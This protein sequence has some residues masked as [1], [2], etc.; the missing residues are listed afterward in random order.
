MNLFTPHCT[1]SIHTVYRKQRARSEQERQDVLDQ[2]GISIKDWM[3]GNNP[4]SKGGM[5]TPSSK[6][7]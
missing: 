7:I 5:E 2:P 4:H 3:V 1:F 6:T